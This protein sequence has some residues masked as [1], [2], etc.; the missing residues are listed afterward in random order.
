MV[1]EFLDP[2]ENALGLRKLGLTFLG[3]TEIISAH[4]RML[5]RRPKIPALYR[6]V[7]IAGLGGARTGREAPNGQWWGSGRWALAVPATC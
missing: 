4:L 2:L 5:E 6:Q 1:S 3:A 7:V